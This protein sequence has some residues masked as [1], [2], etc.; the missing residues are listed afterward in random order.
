M[1]EALL[2]APSNETLFLSSAFP[3]VVLPRLSVMP[4]IATY[5]SETTSGRNTN[6]SGAGLVAA[7]RLLEPF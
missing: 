4:F 2:V 3:A 7:T 6:V 5:Q 1:L